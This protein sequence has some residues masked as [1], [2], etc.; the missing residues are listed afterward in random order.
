MKKYALLFFM[1]AVVITGASAQFRYYF[2]GSFNTKLATWVVPTGERAR[3]T[4]SFGGNTYYNDTARNASNSRGDYSYTAGS[5]DLF[6]YGRGVT[7]VGGNEVYMNLAYRHPNVNFY[8]RLGLTALADGAYSAQNQ[9]TG[10]NEIT[11][12]HS[13]LNG[14]GRTMNWGDFLLNRI[15]DWNVVGNFD[16]QSVN[17]SLFVGNTDDGGSVRL[18]YVTNEYYLY[19]IR[20]ERY[21]V[22]TPSANGADFA[23]MD[24]SNLGGV[25][26]LALNDSY[27]SSSQMPRIAFTART[28]QF[29][30]PLL[31]TLNADVGTNVYRDAIA[32]YRRFSGAARITGQNIGRKATV[33]ATYRFRGYDPD[34]IDNY[35]AEYNPGGTLQPDGRGIGVHQFGLYADLLGIKNWGIAFGYGN[36]FKVFEDDANSYKDTTGETVTKTGPL[37]S[38]FDLR[39]QYTG[40]KQVAV[41]Y[42]GNVSFAKNH[43]GD[44]IGVWGQTLSPDCLQSWFALYNTLCVTYTM[45]NQ[46]STSF[47]VGMR[48]GIVNNE[49]TPADSEAYEY[50]RSIFKIGGGWYFSYRFGSFSVRG[51]VAVGWINH[52]YNNSRSDAQAAAA[53]RNAAGGLFN[54]AVPIGVRYQ[55]GN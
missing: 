37:F 9:G 52:E 49:F 29:G 20:V 12:G 22:L 13:L 14:N 42:N 31:F 11:R 18:F 48:Y 16:I 30:F 53:T 32:D 2:Q 10:Q 38:G 7:S 55:F 54:I 46:F 51:G 34:A 47:M 4:I 39:F 6:N 33:V 1:S 23:S 45:N 8:T 36:A 43:D 24:N 25:T 40:I 28:N 35:D 21:G 44:L 15:S 26:G 19:T 41:T 3:E 27:R 17:L 5:L 50:Y